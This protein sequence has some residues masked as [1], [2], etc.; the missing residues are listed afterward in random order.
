MAGIG[1]GSWCDIFCGFG[2]VY[3]TWICHYGIIQSGF[4]ALKTLLFLP[5]YPLSLTP[6]DHPSS[7]VSIV[8]PFPECHRLGI[9]G[10]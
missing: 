6:G 5:M 4:T 9:H 8:L 1:V 3:N 10:I 2:Q 7:M